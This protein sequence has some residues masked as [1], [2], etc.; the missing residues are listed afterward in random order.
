MKKFLKSTLL[1]LF[2]CML[3][4]ITANAA[5]NPNAIGAGTYLVGRDIPAGEYLLESSRTNYVEV[6]TDLT[7]DFGSII[8]NDNFSGRKYLTVAD[9]TYLT[10]D[11]G[12][13]TPSALVPA[14][15]SPDGTY[16]KGMYLVG[17][18]MPAGEYLITDSKTSYMAVYSNSTDQMGSIVTNENFKNR[19]Y[20]TVFDGQ[21]LEIDGTA[22]PSVAAPAAVP[23][24][25]MYPEGM[26]LVGKDIPEGTY[27]LVPEPGASAYYSIESNSTGQMG[28]IVD[29]DIFKTPI[30]VSLKTGQYINL[31][32]C[33]LVLA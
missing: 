26:Y 9:G 30:A 7:G 23:I 31:S 6:T 15:V 10:F 24:N 29:N 12:T 32:R 28:S 4:P 19:Y 1:A 11:R 3:L 25:N 8:C 22:V 21:Y 33:T 2:C 14:Y 27:Q 16:G 20:V 5:A 17:K 18:D 13:A